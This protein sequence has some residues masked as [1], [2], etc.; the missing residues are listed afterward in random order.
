MHVLAKKQPRRSAELIE[1]HSGPTQ[2]ELA[3]HLGVSQTTVC[4]VLNGH[5]SVAPDMRERVSAAIEELGYTPNLYARSLVS[6]SSATIGVL[7]TSTSV[8]T[9]LLRLTALTSRLMEE[10]WLVVNA[11]TDGTAETETV[12]LNEFEGRMVDGLVCIQ[13]Q[14]VPDEM[15]YRRFVDRG[16]PVVV[17]SQDP[18]P[19]IRTIANE[20]SGGI[21]DAVTHLAE[22]GHRRIVL[23]TTESRSAEMHQRDIGFLR[24]MKRFG[25]PATEDQIIRMSIRADRRAGLTPPD[26]HEFPAG[27]EGR[28]RPQND[29]DAGYLGAA[30]IFERWTESQRPTAL[31]CA[32]DGLAIGAMRL[33]RLRGVRVP[34]QMSVTGFN[35]LDDTR[36]CDP[37]LT[38]TEVDYPALGRLGADLL[39][40]DLAS[41]RTPEAHESH[42]RVVGHFRVRQSTAP[43]AP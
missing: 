32:T 40:R 34:T 15:L 26:S 1:R 10:G 14:H 7:L 27:T 20:I 23:L 9:H 30:E 2:I 41:G 13:R 22:L 5:P 19:R 42:H 37:P 4:R 31:V 36:Y 18:I 25:L 29:F 33:L 39:L 28:D 8:P 24:G 16:R 3:R 21:D 6:Q 17:Y 35:G 12:G 11:L 38:T 43:P